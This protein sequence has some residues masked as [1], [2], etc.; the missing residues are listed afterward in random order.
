[1]SGAKVDARNVLPEEVSMKRYM[2]DVAT[3]LPEHSTHPRN[4]FKGAILVLLLFLFVVVNG[5]TTGAQERDT[6]LTRKEAQ[7]KKKRTPLLTLRGHR[8]RIF[9]L[10]YSP[11]GRRLASASEDR[12]VKVWDTS[13]G[14]LLRTLEG[15]TANV[16]G[17]AFSPDGKRIASAAGGRGELPNEPG[18]VIVWDALTGKSAVVIRGHTGAVYGV[19]FSPDGTRIASA[20][21]DRTVKVWDAATGKEALTL[22]GHSGNVYTVAFSPDGTR[23]ASASGDFHQAKFGEMKV[24]DAITG[25]E[26]YTITGHKGAVYTVMFRPDGRYLA[27]TGGDQT[28]GVWEVATGRQ[29]LSLTGHEGP[30]YSVAFSPDGRRLV[31][32]GS[33]H[34][35]RLWNAVTGQEILALPGHPEQFTVVAF[36]PDG[37]RIASACGS[38]S[39]VMTWDVADVSDQPPLPT[40]V[41]TAERLKALWTDLGGE[42]ARQAYNAVWDLAAVPGQAAPFLQDRLRPAVA[43]PPDP[44]IARLIADLDD[45]RYTV[46]EAATAELAGLGT[47]A[48]QALRKAL[49]RRPSVEARRRIE[50]LL[51]K[52]DWHT[53]SPDELRLLRAVGALEQM[54]TSAAETLLATLTKGA[55]DAPLTREA[56]AA[57]D[58]LA[59]RRNTLP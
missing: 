39:T 10:V 50:D 32:A 12:T 47:S 6:D 3:L 41:L 25:K 49:E 35:A 9:R 52:P 22:A 11:D 23:L 36:S 56:K 7:A 17:L 28:L 57:L 43:V 53:P 5:N 46:R 8:G 40:T 14:E 13:T 34:T 30:V 51:D 38:G 26:S 37:K 20:G 55:P 58:R 45:D 1:M 44:R 29:V 42:D 2:S 48:R 24:W 27:S 59:Q 21:S 18:E 16:C 31:S 4:S 15:H 54:G 33:D 19:A